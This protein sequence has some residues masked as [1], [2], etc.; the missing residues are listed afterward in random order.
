MAVRK[1]VVAG[2]FYESDFNALDEQIKECFRHQ[3]GP[4][5]L[6]AKR[7]D[8]I[9]RGA[10]VPHAGYVF[11]GPCAAWVYK[12]IAESRPVDL[13]ILLGPNHTGMG[14]TS[15]WLEDWQ[16]PFGVVRVDSLFGKK[17]VTNS[18]L[19]NLPGA[20]LHEHSIEV[21]LPFI[22]FTNRDTIHKMT[23][24]PIVVDHDA[25]IK[26]LALELKDA[27]VDSDKNICIIASS[28]FTHYGPMYH[29]VPFSSDVQKRLHELDMGAIKL[30]KKFDVEGFGKYIQETGATICGYLPIML[31]METLSKG[32]VNLLQY[33]TSGDIMGDYRNAVGYAAITIE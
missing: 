27:I 10:I 15:T 16:T 7:R 32:K 29:Y 18:K 1:P 8:K 4:G 26:R 25:D 9:I 20:H 30:I 17:L 5:D 14:G 22:Q 11:S 19:P 12:E 21:Q 33:Y 6:P 23:I 24:L 13:F 31:L 28:D 2:Q 3:K